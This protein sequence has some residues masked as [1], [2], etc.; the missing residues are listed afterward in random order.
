MVTVE[1]VKKNPST[2]SPPPLWAPLAGHLMLAVIK[3]PVA[4]VLMWVAS[5][6]GWTRS[7][8]LGSLIVAVV[9]TAIVGEILATVIERPFVIKRRLSAPGGWGYALSPLFAQAVTGMATGILMFRSLKE[10]IV[11]TVAYILT[12]VVE[13]SL[14]RSWVPGDTQS[15]VDAKWEKTK[16]M[17]HKIFEEDIKEIKKRSAEKSRNNFYKKNADR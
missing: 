7:F 15:Q 11:L 12:T 5:L 1:S 17:T 10:S 14:T 13:I 9:S 16:D 6:L 4:V 3:V 8:P 2:W